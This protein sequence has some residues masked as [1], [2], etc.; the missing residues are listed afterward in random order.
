MGAFKLNQSLLAGPNDSIS[1]V[2]AD[3]TGHSTFGR[4]VQFKIR[5]D[6][7]GELRVLGLVLYVV[8]AGERRL[9]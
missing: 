1:E 4:W 8:T 2:R 7:D 3:Q 5:Q 6:A 9:Q